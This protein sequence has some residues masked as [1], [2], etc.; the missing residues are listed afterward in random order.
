MHSW[1]DGISAFTVAAELNGLQT[2]RVKI[3]D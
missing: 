1:R 2:S 3:N